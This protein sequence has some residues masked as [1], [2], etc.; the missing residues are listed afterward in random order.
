MTG[1]LGNRHGAGYDTSKPMIPMDFPSCGSV[2]DSKHNQ[3]N[4]CLKG[5]GQTDRMQP[6]KLLQL[7]AE[8]CAVVLLP[9]ESSLQAL[10]LL[11]LTAQLCLQSQ[12][13]HR[14]GPL[15]ATITTGIY[16]PLNATKLW[17]LVTDKLIRWTLKGDIG[18]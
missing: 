3:L 10:P 16:N 11:L 13:G 1:S 5:G 17:K 15:N 6:L 7:C 2:H 12:P 18:D 8:L 14:G 9:L 4:V